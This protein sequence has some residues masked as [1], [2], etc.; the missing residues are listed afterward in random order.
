MKTVETFKVAL[1]LLFLV[2]FSACTPSYNV[3]VDAIC[4]PTSLEKKKYFLFSK[5]ESDQESNL[6]DLEFSSYT[7][8]ALRQKKF[9]KTDDITQADIA[10]FF[11]YGISEPVVYTYDVPIIGKTGISSSTI[12]GKFDYFG[13]YSETT[14]Y[15]PKYG[16]TGYRTEKSTIFYR[17]LTIS[18]FDLEKYEQTG[19]F[20]EAKEIWKT[21]VTSWG[22]SSD[23]RK[24]F[25]ILLNVGKGYFGANTRGKIEID[26]Y[27][28]EAWSRDIDALYSKPKAHSNKS[29]EL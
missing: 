3:S 9:I 8:N 5:N 28:N 24:I 6:Q 26:V 25:P 13:N 27:E 23:L 16:I 21:R 12:S 2:W 29:L 17:Y 22:A 11:S 20:Q 10:I 7:D 14:D 19:D 15:T 1:L 4:S 18:G